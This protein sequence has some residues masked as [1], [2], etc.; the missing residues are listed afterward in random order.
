M[1]RQPRL[2]IP[3]L[4]QHVI[5]RGIE[6]RHIF[7][8]DRDRQRF[9]ERFGQLLTNTGTDCYAW[10]LIPNHF[11]L[12]L[13]CNRVELSRFM[14]RLLTGHAVYFNLR[15]NRSG[16]LFQNRYKSIVC[17]E[18]SY[19][20][21]LIRYI[22][23]NPLRAGQVTNLEELARYPWCGHSVLLGHHVLPG[24]AV[25]V[26]LASFGKWKARQ[27]Y[28]QFI[29]DGLEMGEQPHLVGKKQRLGENCSDFGKGSIVP[30]ERILGSRDF[31]ETLDGQ[32][33]FNGRPQD[34]KSLAELQ[35][36]VANFFKMDPRNLGQRGRQNDISSARALFCFLA[37][38]KLR[39]S[40]VQVR[41][42]LGVSG[43]SVSRAA[44]RGAE[45]F[46]SRE[47]LPV[48]W[49]SLFNALK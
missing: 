31:V 35:E 29:V 38:T 26:V 21:E 7:L 23:L 36:D 3:G 34:R 44:R 22:H 9:V 10:A 20:Q 14:R 8:D 43:P 13:R 46:W 47:D 12:L 4:L 41:E 28:H 19:F 30:D 27:R 16:H 39:Y 15:H 33:I 5:V 32:E 17:E 49:D 11:H 2:D 42:M 24:Q 45:L 25:D 37:V 48:W 18:D 1:P 40:G 6:R